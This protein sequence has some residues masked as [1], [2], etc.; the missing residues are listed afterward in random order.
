MK[1]K[2]KASLQTKYSTQRIERQISQGPTNSS[3]K[4][5]LHKAPSLQ[6]PL[7][8]AKLNNKRSV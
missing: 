6:L 1:S 2:N 5:I 3:R 8:F 4:H 7:P